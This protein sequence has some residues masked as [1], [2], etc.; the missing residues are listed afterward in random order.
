MNRLEKGGF[1]NVKIPKSQVV[2]GTGLI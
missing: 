1:V 2:Q